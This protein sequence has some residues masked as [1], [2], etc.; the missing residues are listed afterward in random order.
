MRIAP[1][2]SD[3]WD[4]GG[5]FNAHSI[6]TVQLPWPTNDPAVKDGDEDHVIHPT[7]NYVGLQEARGIPIRWFQKA[8]QSQTEREIPNI[9]QI[10]IDRSIETDAA[11]CTVTLTNQWMYNNGA[12]PAA[13]L[14]EGNRHLNGYFTP[15]RGTQPDAQARW[16]QEANEWENVLL[17]NALLRTYQGYGGHE[18]TLAQCLA[19]GNLILTGMWLIDEVRVSTNGEL[20]IQARDMGKLL[21]DQQLYPPLVPS[22]RYPLSY[23]RWVI[24][25]FDVN[26]ENVTNTTTSTSQ[27]VVAPGDKRVTYRTSSVD[28]W[29]GPGTV[30]HGHRGTD[31]IDKNVQTFWLSEG[32]SGPD[33]AFA[34]SY[35]EY[36]C[37]EWMNAVYVHPWAGNYQMYVSIYENG[38]WQG[39]NTVPYDPSE[40][41]GNQPT[42]VNT[43]ANIPYVRMF[44][45]SFESGK[46]YVL[47]RAYKADRVRISFRHLSYST[48]GPWYYR[49]GVREFRIRATANIGVVSTNT[50]TTTTTTTPYFFAAAGLRN[51]DNL[52]AEG[53]LTV[54]Q[55]NQIDAFG[56]VRLLPRT[57]TSAP[58]N[59]Q[60][61]WC[62]LTRS[63]DGY[64]VLHSD[65]TV[66]A[67][68]AAPY[69][70]SPYEDGQVGPNQSS[71]NNPTSWATICPTPT[72]QG[73]WVVRANGN[74]RAYGD[75][76]GRLPN[77]VTGFTFSNGQSWI[78]GG[79]ALPNDY[80]ILVCSNDGYVYALGDATHYGNWTETTLVTGE[81]LC[82]V[83]S[84]MAGDGYWMMTTTGRV[85]AVG[86]AVDHGQTNSPSLAYPHEQLLPTGT[87][88]GY[89]IMQ[90]GG[91][92][93]AFGQAT[94]YG[95]P[96]PDSQGQL[97]SD[98][99]YLD[100]SDIIKDLALWAGFMLY[101]ETLPGSSAPYVYG[102]IEST[103][104]YSKEQ[105]PDEIFDKRPVID[106]MTEL[107]EAVGYLLFVDD[108]GG[109]R[110]ES[111]N[112]WSYGNWDQATGER[113]F[114]TPIIDE[115]TNLFDYGTS[116]NDESLRSMIII[117][118][119]DPNDAGDTTV[120]T[121]IVPQTAQGLRG[122]LKP[123]M[124]V[125]GWFQD[126]VEQ[127]IMAELI[128]M[129]IWFAQ[130]LGQVTCVAN[131]CIQIND[132]VRI[133]E[134]STS[135]VFVHYVRGVNTTHNL[136]DGTYTMTLTTHWLGTGE[137]WAITDSPD[138]IADEDHYVIS[139]DLGAQLRERGIITGS[140]LDLISVD[141]NTA[142]PQDPLGPTGNPSE[143]TE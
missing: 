7:R 5:P 22:S 137:D 105:L 6:V 141:P 123:A 142:A 26:S 13:H 10:T 76:V 45:T 30:L 108:E 103:G 4:A 54:S 132:Q 78:S 53:Y 73:Y 111:P 56:D 107:K 35:I 102:N 85:Q 130:R 124:W 119:E 110:F 50:S 3:L 71:I 106:A 136:D 49:A 74:I 100:Y 66:V 48:I 64:W 16:N 115:M 55:M 36:N 42:V 72:S 101:D 28:A 40:L 80:G 90:T 120:T 109:L 31:S 61:L 82:A 8:D 118:S 95:S 67:Y 69:F 93:T 65:G 127:K 126:E 58:T 97:R 62:A 121:T 46:E 104:S 81:S 79:T 125:N 60:V 59:A 52:N 63:G 18:K 37:G 41:Y 114:N 140:D 86:A 21:I 134:R 135:E 19:D 77:D 138:Y 128:A 133:F 2:I 139:A 29:Y 44:G 112:F 24:T 91:L 113:I 43:G 12:V 33:R 122:L 11:T 14:A 38:Q 20:T 47:P 92:V 15:T 68:G 25:N 23:Y 27:V 94:Y 9:K 57:S 39:T 99:N 143:G 70:G 34:T 96:V 83:V 51:P 117:S 98:G 88:L 32:S 131:P 1:V 87:D 17:P 84:T 116:R 129:H 89:Q 75:A